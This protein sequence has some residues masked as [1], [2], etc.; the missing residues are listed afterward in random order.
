MMTASPPTYVTAPA[1]REAAFLGT[2]SG[3]RLR[4]AFDEH[5]GL[6]NNETRFY[7]RNIGG[8][9]YAGTPLVCYTLE[10][11]RLWNAVK[12]SC[13]ATG[14]YEVLVRYDHRDRRQ[15]ELTGVPKRGNIQIHVGNI[16]PDSQDCI[17]VCMS[18]T[19]SRV[20]HSTA[21]HSQLNAAFYRA[22]QR[23]V[24]PPYRV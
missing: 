21:A 11:A 15:L 17:L 9:L 18:Y 10:R 8:E 20:V 23:R 7:T 14:E 4:G 13:I 5:A 6:F 12:T 3:H 16:P 2:H 24:S 22:G 1:L 19:D